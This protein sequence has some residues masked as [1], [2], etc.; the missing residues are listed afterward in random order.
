M[1]RNSLEVNK[2]AEFMYKKEKQNKKMARED[3]MDA[4][5]EEVMDL[6]G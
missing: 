6:T 1:F 4:A 5:A 2:R 3:S